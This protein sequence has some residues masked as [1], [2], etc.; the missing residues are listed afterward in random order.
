MSGCQVLNEVVINQV[1]FR[2]TDDQTTEQVLRRVVDSGEA[3]MSGTTFDGR[4]AIRLSA[5]S[6]QTSEL[7]LSARWWAANPTAYWVHEP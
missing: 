2:F 1:L 6:W 5:S 3:W 4:K 7:R